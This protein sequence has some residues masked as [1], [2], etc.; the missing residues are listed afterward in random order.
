MS[1]ARAFAIP[2]VALSLCGTAVSAQEQKAQVAVTVQVLWEATKEP[3]PGARVYDHIPNQLLAVTQPDGKV[4]LTLLNGTVLRVVDPFYGT[5]QGL[6]TVAG[7]G[8]AGAL[9]DARI[10]Y[11]GTW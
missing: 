9:A 3:V 8:P 4:T 6:M 1:T 7:K 11:W 10:F 2:A 5:R